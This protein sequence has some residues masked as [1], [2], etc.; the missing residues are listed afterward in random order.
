MRCM[1]RYDFV[2][3]DISVFHFLLKVTVVAPPIRTSP[4]AVTGIIQHP[5][6]SKHT[7]LQVKH[8]LQYDPIAL[9]Y[10]KLHQALYKAKHPAATQ[11]IGYSLQ[12]KLLGICCPVFF[13]NCCVFALYVVWRAILCY[14]VEKLEKVRF[15]PVLP[16]NVEE[17]QQKVT[18]PAS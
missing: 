13:S 15:V 2:Y 4:T 7:S 18:W 14:T 8:L 11:P 6:A 3:H 12:L 16:C 10:M 1:V 17:W 5:A 9:H